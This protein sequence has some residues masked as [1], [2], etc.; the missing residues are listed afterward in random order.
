MY[1]IYH[2]EGVKIGVSTNPSKRVKQQG[3]TDFKILET[4]N[5]IYKVSERELELQKEYGYDDGGYVP[6]YQT[7][8]IATK[9]K[10]TEKPIKAYIADTKEFVKEYES[11]GKAAN[12]LGLRRNLISMV[13]TKSKYRTQTGGYYFE[14]V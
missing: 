3:Y 2:V 12:E 4:H 11:V 5:D 8:K 14:Y 6:Y 9:S 10:K 13:L 1:Y 7:V